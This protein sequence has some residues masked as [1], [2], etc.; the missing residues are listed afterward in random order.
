[1]ADLRLASEPNLAVLI[2]RAAVRTPRRPGGDAPLPPGSAVLDGYRTDPNRLAAYDRV[3]GFALRDNVPATWLHVLTFPLQAALLAAPDFPYGIAGLLHASNAMTLH[4]PV[5]VTDALAMAVRVENARAHRRGVLFDM[6]SEVRVDG[7][8]AWSGRSTYLIASPKK[9]AGEVR[10]EEPLEAPDVVPSQRWR[11]A[12]DLGR[13]YAGVSGD[14]NPIHLHPATARLCGFRRPIIHG[15]W[16]HARALAAL[17]G[18]LPGTYR[19]RVR[20]TRP[21][22]LPTSVGFGAVESGRETRFVVSNR[23]GKPAMVGE[24]RP[25]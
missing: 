6:V 14:V 25:V 10:D 9:P 13:R 8:L 16:T 22:L 2:A 5:R 18:R 23:D 1:M 7:E 19:V 12:S 24:V 21:L 11:L 3:C 20:F 4:R 17:E 15:M